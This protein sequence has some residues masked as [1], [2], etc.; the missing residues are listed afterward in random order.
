MAQAAVAGLG[1]ES[2]RGDDVE[3]SRD[4]VSWRRAH[5]ELVRLAATRAGLDCEE[6]RWLLR[7]LRAGAHVRLRYGSFREYTT[8]LFGYS[9]RLTQ[10][11]IRVAEALEGL[12]ELSRELQHGSVSFSAARELTRVATAATEGKWLEA[13]HGRAIREV[14]ELVSGHRPGSLPDDAPDPRA[15]RHVLRLEVSGEVLAT[16]RE[17]MAK[18]RRDAGEALD[19]DAAVLLLCRQ[20]GPR[21]DGRSS[22]QVALTVCERCRHGMQQGRGHNVDVAPE[23][24]EMAECDGQHLGHVESCAHGGANDE[25]TGAD[26]DANTHVGTHRA[27]QTIPPAL[28]RAVLR[29]DE[30]RCRVPGCR[31]AVFTDVHHL[32]LRS[33]SG[34]HSLENLATLCSAHHRAVHRGELLTEGTASNGLSFLHADGTPYGGAPSPHGAD[35][36]AKAFRALTGMGYRETE[37]KRALAKIPVNSNV[38]LEQLVRLTLRELVSV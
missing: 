34:A 15:K 37:A 16:F 21:D 18:V 1:E 27:T 25:P 36:R 6:G 17:A 4:V 12:P 11:K 26:V 38:A 28:R 20:E 9:P 10:E 8:R 32:R 13:A 5:E 29:R 2:T 24:V 7:A 19:D 14:E 31:H 23:V 3:G 30:G 33:E 22:Y 35:V